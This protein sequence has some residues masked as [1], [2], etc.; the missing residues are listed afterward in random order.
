MEN[1]TRGQSELQKE[2]KGQ[3]TQAIPHN[4]LADKE[5]ELMQMRVQLHEEKTLCK[6]LDQRNRTMDVDMEDQSRAWLAR[7]RLIYVMCFDSC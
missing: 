6:Q 1:L 7:N 4:L 5:Y 2:L 3:Q